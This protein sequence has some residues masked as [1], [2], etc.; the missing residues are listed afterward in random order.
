MAATGLD[1]F[2]QTLQQ[3]N[4]WL[5]D[6]G[7]ELHRDDVHTAYLALRATL[8]ALRDNLTIDEAADLAA[9]LPMLIRGI[10][11]DGWNPAIVP[12]LDRSRTAFLDRIERAMG[13][14]QPDFPA[15]LAARAVLRTLSAQ[16]SRGEIDEVRNT[17]TEEIRELW[18]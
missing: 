9:Q 11:F 8:H 16:V 3:S 13:R 5:N 10:Y 18:N 14:A 2:D 1:V 4:I 6:I 17:L 12:V 7:N 15:E